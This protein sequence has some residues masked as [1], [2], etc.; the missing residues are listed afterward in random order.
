MDTDSFRTYMEA[1]IPSVSGRRG[2][3]MIQYHKR[4]MRS[5]VYARRH[6]GRTVKNV[7]LT[8]GFSSSSLTGP[9][10]EYTVSY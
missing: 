8:L 4:R 10:R 1:D 7:T 6:L 2:S 9:A 5:M 3:T